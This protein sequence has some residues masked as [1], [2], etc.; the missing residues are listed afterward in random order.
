M[1]LFRTDLI[2][3]LNNTLFEIPVNELNTGEFVITKEYL[4]CALTSCPSMDGYKLNGT[5]E[6]TT[7]ET[8]D[9]CLND[10]EQPHQIP[11]TLWLT[12]NQEVLTDKSDDI[13]PF[14][15]NQDWVDLSDT[16]Q[17]LIFLDKPIITV[18][19]ESCKGLCTT[20][21]HNLNNSNC[22]CPVN[23]IN[24]RWNVLKK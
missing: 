24:D 6:L 21:G 14:P 4:Q 16:I 5:L 12:S 11:L 9:R 15:D 10:Y 2:N 17:D 20:C 19:K 8:C 13:I 3:G 7:I 23:S 22:D 1:K 18:C